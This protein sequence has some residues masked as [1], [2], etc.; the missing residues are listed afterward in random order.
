MKRITP[1]LYSG[2]AVLH[3]KEGDEKLEMQYRVLGIY[4]DYFR[5]RA[6]SAQH[7]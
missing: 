6:S 5:D 1:I 2:S 3:K 7:G 4:D